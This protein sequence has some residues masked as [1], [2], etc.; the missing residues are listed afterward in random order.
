MQNATK[1]ENEKSEIAK[2]FSAAV[3]ELAE[4]SPSTWSAANSGALGVRLLGAVRDAD[5][6]AVELNR[7]QQDAVHAVFDPKRLQMKEID[8]IAQECNA[9]LDD[10]TRELL[11]R[12]LDPVKFQQDLI[13]AGLKKPTRPKRAS[14]AQLVG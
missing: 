1:A 12:F 11:E 14:L 4:A 6:N 7:E 13:V 9:V 10:E 3:K 5:G 8:R 2:L